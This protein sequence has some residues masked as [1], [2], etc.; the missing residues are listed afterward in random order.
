MVVKRVRYAGVYSHE[1]DLEGSGLTIACCPP[2]D[3]LYVS[4]G[5]PGV[6][7]TVSDHVLVNI[8]VQ[9]F[10]SGLRGSTAGWF[11]KTVKFES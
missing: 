8:R 6:C 5:T 7:D 4:N 1:Q 10:Y 2:C 11:S 9:T 3:V